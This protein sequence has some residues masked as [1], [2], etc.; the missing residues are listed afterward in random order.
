MREKERATEEQ[1]AALLLSIKAVSLSPADPYTWAS[2]LRS[3]IYCDNRLLMG[4]PEARAAVTAAFSTL[5]AGLALDVD[6]L[7]GTATAGIPHAAWLA[8]ETRLP[9]IYVRSKPK[10]HGRQ[11]Q[12]EGPLNAGQSVVVIEDLI[13]TGKSSVAAVEALQAAGADVQAVLAIFSYGFDD[14]Q[15]MFDRAGVPFYT[16]TNFETLITVAE[17]EGRLPPDALEAMR[18]WRSDPRAWSEQFESS[19]F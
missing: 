9:M 10:G 14:A 11:N 8:H 15:R 17:Q 6:V 16:L 4:Y 5:L 7:A 2:G 19:L 13:S 12:I 1:I 18:A 3:P